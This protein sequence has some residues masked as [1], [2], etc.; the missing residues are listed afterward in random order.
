MTRQGEKRGMFSMKD[1]LT[2]RM[3]GYSCEG[4]WNPIVRKMV[5]KKGCR[6]SKGILG[7]GVA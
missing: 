4:H 6:D 2:K 7:A 3:R 1:T 5:G